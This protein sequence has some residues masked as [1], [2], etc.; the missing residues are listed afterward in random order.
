MK[1]IRLFAERFLSLGQV[2]FS[3]DREGTTLVEGVNEDAPA[4]SNGAGK[5]SLFEAIFWCLFGAT[6][7][8]LK[9]DEIINTHIKGGACVQF[10]FEIKGVHYTAIRTRRYSKAGTGF[11]LF[12]GLAEIDEKGEIS[13]GITTEDLTKGTMKDTQEKLEDI[14]GMGRLA[15]E[16]CAFF[17][18][19]DIKPFASLTDSERKLVFE[20]A[21]NLSQLSEDAAKVAGFRKGKQAEIDRLI[22]EEDAVKIR[23]TAATEELDSLKESLS[24]FETVR[25]SKID[26]LALE[27]KSISGLTT[28]FNSKAE[29]IEERKV[30][31]SEQLA[32]LPLKIEEAEKIAAQFGEKFVLASS[33]S[34]TLHAQLKHAQKF[35]D[36]LLEKIEDARVRVGVDCETCGMKMTKEASD[37]MVS[38][39]TERMPVVHR[40]V[41]GIK[42]NFESKTDLVT[43]MDALR[44][45]FTEKLKGFKE[46]LVELNRQSYAL[47]ESE[48]L[49]TLRINTGKADVE[50]INN[51][52]KEIRAETDKATTHRIA[53]LEEARFALLT[54]VDDIGSSKMG[55]GH[56]IDIAE[57]IERALGNGGLKSL[58]FDNVTPSLNE[59]A[60]DFMGILNPEMT[61]E[62]STVTKLATGE[63][64]D[65]F[66]LNVENKTGAPVFNGN[67]G[68]EKQIVN[69]A[70][71]L[72][73]NKQMR[74]MS[75]TTPEFLV[76]DEPFENL[77]AGASEQVI[78]LMKHIDSNNI[79]LVTHNQDVKDL[80]PSRIKVTKKEGIAML[81]E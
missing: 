19:G 64:R 42:E 81:T 45:P 79:F 53:E 43:R 12:R 49:N 46:E 62:L 1:P 75:S 76:L 39:F 23:L 30:A 68:G 9:G 70:I 50:R 35:K 57:K 74:S 77:D 31:V 10:E 33:E 14:I 7:R 40:H 56:E 71:A 29:E 52:V 22:I 80:I 13:E 48:S 38:T 18:Q 54:Q 24:I 6:R 3:F 63:L 36:E 65:K 67:S 58:I 15:F 20:Q 72:A 78:E 41:V 59:Y 47:S 27:L 44:E 21:M 2:N 25:V 34:A 51:Q 16:K 66:S 28:E 8:P 37:E 4:D 55:Y 60:N 69:L 32:G 26:N 61:V 73:F 11:R 5:S 17:G